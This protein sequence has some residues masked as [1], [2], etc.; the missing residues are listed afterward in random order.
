[1]FF[2]TYLASPRT[3][4]RFVGYL[5]EE[6]VKTYT[7]AIEALENGQMPTWTDKDAPH[8]AKT[9]W[10]LAEDAK[11]IDVLLAVVSNCWS[12]F[13]VSLTN[14]MYSGLTN[15]TIAMSTTP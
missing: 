15:Q 10:G 14:G 4:H 3:C 13:V 1:M 12:C 7:T 2:F 5:E 6:A 9:Y 8:I 11:M